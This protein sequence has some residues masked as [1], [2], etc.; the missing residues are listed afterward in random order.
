M[1][2]FD[3][4]VLEFIKD[5]G[6]EDAYIVQP[7]TGAYN[8]ATATAAG[9]PTLLPCEG[10][11]MDLTLQSNGMSTKY[12]TVV[13]AG[14]KEFMMR[15]PHKTNAYETPVTI[16]PSEDQLV[17]GD[18]TYDIVT[19]KELNPTGTNPVLISLYLRR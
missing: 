11:L 17:I 5:Y 3:L 18:I 1:E 8:P 9:N 14:D 2:D 16:R 7:S 6:A 19:L 12:G 15:P 13:E 10:I 4:T